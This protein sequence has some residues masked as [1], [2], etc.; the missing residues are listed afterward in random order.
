[1]VGVPLWALAHLRIDSEGL[2]G[3]VAMGGYYLILEIFLRPF[4]IIFGMLGGIAIYTA[5]ANILNDIWPL[6]TSNLA[7]FDVPDAANAASPDSTGAIR[8]L[9]G[10]VDQ[11]FF[12]VI[13]AIV[14][15]MLGM[16]SFKMVNLVPNYILR[17][18][19]ANV[20]SFG[21]QGDAAQELVGNVFMESN[22]ILGQV[23]SSVGAAT[24]GLGA[25]A[26]G[27]AQRIGSNG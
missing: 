22:Q 21:E 15:Y 5:Q 11:M 23:K 7:G 19:G 25:A 1:M 24:G 8:F 26:K 10:A 27:L 13:Y 6:V 20:H 9:R 17:W 3:D 14:L 12:T 18:M 2:P 16:S 4:L